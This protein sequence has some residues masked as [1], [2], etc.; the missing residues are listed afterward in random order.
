MFYCCIHY[1]TVGTGEKKDL[2]FWKEVISLRHLWTG[3]IF[4]ALHRFSE[5]SYTTFNF[6]CCMTISRRCA[7]PADTEINLTN[8]QNL[9]FMFG[10]LA[11]IK[12]EYRPLF[13]PPP[14]LP[15]RVWMRKKSF[16]IPHPS[17]TIKLLRIY[18]PFNIFY[19]GPISYISFKTH[20]V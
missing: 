14:P 4:A 5:F 16:P 17:G 18:Y 8:P 9:N 12:E 13:P 15:R 7:I 20:R 1:T 19:I 6:H 10:N 11:M 3:K 2:F